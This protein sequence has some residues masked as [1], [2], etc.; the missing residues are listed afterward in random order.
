MVDILDSS[1]EK[2]INK[3]TI[4]A[5]IGSFIASKSFEINLAISAVGM[6]D[7]FSLGANRIKAEMY[8]HIYEQETEMILK[9]LSFK[10]KFVSSG[11]GD[12][13]FK[14]TRTAQ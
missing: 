2:F 1:N 10:S 14:R 4:N 3:S 11:E 8:F 7:N 6:V 12:S 5:L 9:N 13:D